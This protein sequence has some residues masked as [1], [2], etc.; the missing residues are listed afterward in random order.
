MALPELSKDGLM[1]TTA[2]GFTG[3]RKKIVPIQ[4]EVKAL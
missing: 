4:T 2:P 1:V 3:E